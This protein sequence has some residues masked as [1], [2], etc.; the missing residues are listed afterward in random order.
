M[1]RWVTPP[2]RV[3]LT[4][5]GVP[6]LHVNRPLDQSELALHKSRVGSRLL[7]ELFIASPE[8]PKRVRRFKLFKNQKIQKRI[9]ISTVITCS[10]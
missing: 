3:Y 7:D 4:Y 10:E 5:R 9:L 6:H 2:K 1:D 8:S